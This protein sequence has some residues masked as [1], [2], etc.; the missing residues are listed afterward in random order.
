[1]ALFDQN[2]DNKK[3]WL[4]DKYMSGAHALSISTGILKNFFSE[5]EY[6]WKML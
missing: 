1:M 3:Q 6:L 5:N 4:Y 2:T